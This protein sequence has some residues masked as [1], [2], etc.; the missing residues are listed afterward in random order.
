MENIIQ[1]DAN[2]SSLDVIKNKSRL[3]DNLPRISSNI[4][5][6]FSLCGIEARQK[7]TSS[8]QKFLHVRVKAGLN[9]D[10]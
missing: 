6:L 9:F 4:E 2:E 8:A 3:A 1:F 7:L 10:L 5:Q